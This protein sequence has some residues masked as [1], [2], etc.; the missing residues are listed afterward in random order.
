MVTAATPRESSSRERDFVWRVRLESAVD[1]R[2]RGRFKKDHFERAVDWREKGRF[3][4]EMFS[5][6][7]FFEIGRVRFEEIVER[8]GEVVARKEIFT[9]NSSK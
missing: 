6:E 3:D 1:W 5:K 2:E 8:K 7:V 9:Q 4:R